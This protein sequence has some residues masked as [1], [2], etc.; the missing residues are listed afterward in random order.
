MKRA[1]KPVI[2][3]HCAQPAENGRKETGMESYRSAIIRILDM[4][5]SPRM[6][7]TIY[8][9]VHAIFINQQQG[10]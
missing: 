4:I 3:S 2:L 6:M 8:D 10:G 5:D 1:R 9:I 7:R